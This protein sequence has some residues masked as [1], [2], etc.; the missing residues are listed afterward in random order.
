MS[1]SFITPQKSHVNK[2]PL[3]AH[4]VNA[5]PHFSFI[6]TIKGKTKI[7]FNSNASQVIHFPIQPTPPLTFE[8]SENGIV[9]R[10]TRH[11]FLILALV[12]FSIFTRSTKILTLNPTVALLK[13]K[14]LLIIQQPSHQDI[15]AILKLMPLISSH[16]TI[17]SMMVIF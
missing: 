17:K 9:I 15:L 11:P 10:S 2:V 14:T 16:L 3:T 13:F 4:K 6:H 8:T 12:L 1:F 7:C 5:L